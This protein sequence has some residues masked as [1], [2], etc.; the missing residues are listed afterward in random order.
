[1]LARRP[2][3]AIPDLEAAVRV[4]P[5]DVAALQLLAQVQKTI[6]LTGEAAATQERA[7]RSRDRR[8]LMDRLTKAIDARPDDPD[9]RWRMGQAA[10]E[11]EMDVLAYQ[12]FPAALAR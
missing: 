11:G 12:S 6:G 3:R 4:K 1:F 10:M 9:P 5:N 2:N 8:A 7:D